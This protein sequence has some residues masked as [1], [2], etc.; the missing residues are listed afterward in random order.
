[1]A[2][3]LYAAE[4]LDTRHLLK[5]ASATGAAAILIDAQTGE[6]SIIV[7]PG[8]CYE[9]SPEEVDGMT[10][11]IAGSAIFVTQLEL[12]LPAVEHGL[13]LARSLGV[14]TILNPA[15]GCRLPGSLLALCD[16]VTPNATETEILT[17]IA[18]KS[19]ADAQRAADALLALGAG[20]VVITLGADGAWVKNA[21]IS[22]HIPAF[23]A[24]PVVETTGAGDAFTG[25]FAVALAEGKDLREAARFGCAV[26]GLSV[27][28]AGTALS[29]PLRAEINALMASR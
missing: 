18:V 8:A 16:Y 28:R 11:L 7:V 9:L 2:R 21:S 26:A 15:P 14:P 13:K 23:H 5:S 10:E 3:A 20:N 17:G 29:M 22:T 12:A 25:G 4:G 6:N 19:H 27:T 1:M 24:G